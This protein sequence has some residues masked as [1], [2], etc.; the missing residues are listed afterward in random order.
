[1]VLASFTVSCQ[2]IKDT[3]LKK[4]T[5]LSNRIGEISGVVALSKNQIFAINDSG[6]KNTLFK[7][8]Q[9]GK[10]LEEIRIPGAK[11]VDW[12]D[13]AYDHKGNIYIGDFGNNTN[14]R[15]DLT[16]YKI[17]GLS[18]NKIIVSEIHFFLEDQKKFPP[19]KK[20]LNFDIEAFIY[21]DGSFYLFSKN[22][23]SKFEGTTKLY[24]L[25]ATPG[26]QVAKLIGK[27]NTCNDSSDCFITG[28]AINKKKN[29]IALLTYN[30]LFVISDFKKDH[31]FDGTIQKIKLNHHSQKE[32]ISFKND[33]VLIITDEKAKHKSA[34]LYEYYLD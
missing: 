34:G 4:V 26:K 24:K 10:I 18:S 11:N 28:A 1:M 5:A 27:Y 8:N 2:K 29:K 17:S 7:L 23:S 25:S 31:F 9:E 14:D 12:E 20:N 3:K 16:I 30:K 21:L 6:N 15:K 19:K 32:G 13:L 33:S 22:R